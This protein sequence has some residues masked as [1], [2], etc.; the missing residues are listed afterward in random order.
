MKQVDPLDVFAFIF[1]LVFLV[2]NTRFTSVAREFYLRN[3]EIDHGS[4][5][6]RAAFLLFGSFIVLVAIVRIFN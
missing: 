6:F 2:F 4:A 5:V 3:F 1:G